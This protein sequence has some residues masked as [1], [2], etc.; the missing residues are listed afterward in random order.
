MGWGRPPG[1]LAALKA[2][3]EHECPKVR[4]KLSDAASGLVGMNCGH[5]CA[6]RINVHRGV[7]Q[8][9]FRDSRAATLPVLPLK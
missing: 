1:W 9:K 6:M 5:E 8:A 2:C 3:G 7:W 4:E